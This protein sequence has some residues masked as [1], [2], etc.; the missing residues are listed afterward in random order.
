MSTIDTFS[1]DVS[2][3][4]EFGFAQAIKVGDTIYISGQLSHDDKGDFLHADDLDGQ[5]QQVWA[6]LDKVLAHYGI[7]RNQIVQDGVFVVNLP[8]NAATVASSHLAYF[9]EHRPTSTTVGV[10]ALF[11]PGQLLEINFIAD[12][13]QPA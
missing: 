4:K 6:N 10:E 2:G 8:E 5:F 1:H 3:E 13:R 7:T 11:F 12:T 9:G